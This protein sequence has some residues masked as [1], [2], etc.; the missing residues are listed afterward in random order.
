VLRVHHTGH[1]SEERARGHSSLP[2]MVDTEIRVDKDSVSLTKQRDDTLKGFD[3]ILNEVTVGT[4]Q[5]GEAVTTMIV[6]FVEDNPCSGK[7]TRTLRELLDALVARHGDGGE[8]KATQIG[9]CCPE[10][11]PAEQKRKVRDALVRKQ[12]LLVEGE[13]FKICAAGPAAQFN[14]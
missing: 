12:Y 11:M 1:G 4:D 7:L 9:D 10:H 8:V 2:A 13:K 14:S 5:D 3:F 6:E